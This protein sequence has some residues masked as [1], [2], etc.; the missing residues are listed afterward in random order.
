ME[1]SNLEGFTISGNTNLDKCGGWTKAQPYGGGLL[2]P[3]INTGKRSGW[4]KA[5]P[6]G[7]GLLPPGCQEEYSSFFL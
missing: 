4:T 2:S 5:Q 1:C 3:G 7:G 6:Y